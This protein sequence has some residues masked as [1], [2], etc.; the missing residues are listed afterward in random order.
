M[1][2]AIEWLILISAAARIPASHESAQQRSY[3][4]TRVRPAG[5]GSW[6]ESWSLGTV[7]LAL[8]P[9]VGPD[10]AL[11]MVGGRGVWRS[12]NGV[13]WTRATDRPPWGDRHGA[14]AVFFRGELWALGGEENRV[15][16]RDV[17]HSKDGSRWTRGPDAPWSARRWHTATVFHDQLWILG[18][19]DSSDRN[20]VWVTSDGA[21][22]R[23]VAEH[24]PW[25]P[26]RAHATVVW[27]DQLCVL[28]G[29]S[30]DRVLTDVWC[31]RD[32]RAWS[33]LAEGGWSARLFPGVLV[34]DDRLWVF[35]G[36]AAGASGNATWLNDVRVSD[37]GAQWTEQSRH[38]PWSPRSPEYSV[39]FEDRLWIFG[40][41]GIEA[42]GRGGFATDVWALRASR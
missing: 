37:D 26:R 22:W 12:A 28:G 11:W 36:S 10:R 35:G 17:Y 13:H 2:A 32:G 16:Q 18:G 27:R 33:K 15:K 23:L 31:S 30:G 39:V 38:A 8:T 41:K 5:S 7:P 1:R 19:S 6:Q 21:S 42:N 14:T 25:R 29:S 9:I 40:G 20:D 24:S 3:E 34:F 4:W